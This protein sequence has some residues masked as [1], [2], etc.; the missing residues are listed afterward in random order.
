MIRPKTESTHCSSRPWISNRQSSCTPS[1]VLTP[2]TDDASTIFCRILASSL[3]HTN[4][5]GF[6]IT[7]PSVS[8]NDMLIA[9]K[10][11]FESLRSP[12][13][14]VWKGVSWSFARMLLSS[15]TYFEP[16][17]LNLKPL[18]LPRWKELYRA[19]TCKSHVWYRGTHYA[20]C[21]RRLRTVYSQSDIVISHSSC[22]H[23]TSDHETISAT[24][25]SPYVNRKNGYC[26]SGIV[27]AHAKLCRL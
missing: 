1:D 10:H 18:I 17:M 25:L 19:F 26:V 4:S 13:I 21:K 11:A 16:S 9:K 22:S 24:V 6:L 2:A 27:L 23:C 12:S 3:H 5:I 15:T 7:F 14:S 8:R 20:Q